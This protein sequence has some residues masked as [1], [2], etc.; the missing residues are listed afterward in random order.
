MNKLQRIVLILMAVSF[1][2]ICLTTPRKEYIPDGNRG[3]MLVEK[4][5]YNYLT[6]VSYDYGYL[7]T[8]GLLVLAGGGLLVAAAGGAAKKETENPFK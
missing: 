7:I 4:K 5:G 6:L 1:G 3:G 2:Y 8:R